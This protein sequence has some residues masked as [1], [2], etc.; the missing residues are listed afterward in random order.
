MR[1]L[2]VTP[3]GRAQP[4]VR[5]DFPEPTRAPGELLVESLLIGVCGTDREIVAGSYGDAPPGER[6]LVLG[7]ESLGR[8]L[9]ADPDS[10]FVSGDRVVGIVRRPDPVPCSCCAAG[11]WDMCLNGEYSEHGIRGAHGYARDRYALEASF[12]IK[13]PQSLGDNAVLLEPA[14]VVAKAWE[15]IERV[16]GRCRSFSPTHVLVTGAGP[17]GLLG[18]LLAVQRGYS[19]T[20]LDRAQSGVKPDLVRALGARYTSGPISSITPKPEIVLECTGSDQVVVD[21]LA[22]T[23]RNS[24]VCLAGVSS[25]ARKVTLAASSF[26]D[27]MV[28]ENDLV[29]GSVNANRRHYMKALVALEQ[30]DQS[31]LGRLITRRVALASFR[32][33]LAPRADDVKVVLDMRPR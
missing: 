33:A 23:A 10:G 31:W 9:A 32:E 29:F 8:V 17:V 21:V 7:H 12:A 2:V 1:A 16:A 30:A 19:V 26:N 28:L 3:G 4:R 5:D 6:E 22:Q 13:V 24:T 14:S 20:V 18:A 11:E 15:Q 27:A 25:G